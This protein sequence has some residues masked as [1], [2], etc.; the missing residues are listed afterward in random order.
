MG[1][2]LKVEYEEIIIVVNYGLSADF[3]RRSELAI[4][5][6]LNLCIES[7][8]INLSESHVS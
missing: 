4:L 1:F 5:I 3:H 6:E 2:I 7:G 8:I